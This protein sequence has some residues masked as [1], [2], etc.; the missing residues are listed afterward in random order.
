MLKKDANKPNGRLHYPLPGI[1][2]M[3]LV[4]WTNI[5]NK[6][7][8]SFILFFFFFFFKKKIIIF[9]QL[10]CF[11]NDRKNRKNQRTPE[12]KS[13]LS[14]VAFVYSFASIGREGW[15]YCLWNW[16]RVLIGS[17]R[18]VLCKRSDTLFVCF[19]WSWRCGKLFYSVKHAV[20]T[21]GKR[22]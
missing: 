7:P 13:H 4:P 2:S 9:W 3:K 22:H 8:H 11:Q 17:F 10:L 6:G 20:G 15:L 12:L 16:L 1:Q 18:G 19:L 14:N 21:A 5:E